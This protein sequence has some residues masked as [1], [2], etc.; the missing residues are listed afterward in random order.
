MNRIAEKTILVTGSNGQVGSELQ[1]LASGYP[2]YE[3]LFTTK[4]DLPIGN[5]DA[6][7]KFFFNN[8]VDHCINCA[9]YTHVDKA[10][11]EPGEAY[12]L[13]GDAVGNLARVCNENGTG[14]I[15]FSTDYVFDGNGKTAYKEDDRIAPKNIYG[16]SKLR[17]E[18]LA[19][20]YHSA[21]AIIR[22]SWVYSSFGNN[23]VKTM[24]RLMNEKES[25]NV[26]DDQYGCPTYARDLADVT[27]QLVDKENA[28]GIF[29]FCNSNVTTWYD[30]AEEIKALIKSKCK[31]NPVGSDQ[32]PVKAKRPMFSVLDTR[33]IREFLGMEIRGWEEALKECLEL[34][35]GH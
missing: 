24:V 5:F 1:Q 17:G 15:H 23:F 9:A 21:T 22:T 3:F 28:S 11:S 18:E 33:K 4:S 20:N 6:V 8:Q 32:Y 26:V 29:N 2:Q 12:L 19:L 27:L 10:E 31:I 14:L 25:I 30:F 13:N 16:K 7:K 34:M 35:E